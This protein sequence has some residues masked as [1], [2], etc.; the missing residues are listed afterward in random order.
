MWENSG[1]Q[2][3]SEPGISWGS[4]VI[5]ALNPNIEGGT[6]DLSHTARMD[7]PDSDRQLRPFRPAL[8]SPSA[9]HEVGDAEI[10]RVIGEQPTDGFRRVHLLVRRDRR[11]EGGARYQP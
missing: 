8:A 2:C 4:E 1:G 5:A 11:E 7:R 9:R 3:V 6:F 10:K